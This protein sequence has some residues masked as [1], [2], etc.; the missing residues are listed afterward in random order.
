MGHLWFED[1]LELVG[2]AV[3]ALL[4]LVGLTTIAGAPWTVQPDVA[5]LVGRLLGA[6]GAIAVGAGLL[7]LSRT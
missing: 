6:F 4:V 3:G 1:D 2:L 7:W 5:P